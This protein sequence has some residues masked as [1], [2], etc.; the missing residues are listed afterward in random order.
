MGW[1]QIGALA[2]I[3]LTKVP[4]SQRPRNSTPTNVLDCFVL[5]SVRKK[6]K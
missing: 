2:A 1:G 6:K 5:L 4:G 3:Y